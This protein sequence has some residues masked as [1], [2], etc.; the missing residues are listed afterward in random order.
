MKTKAAVNWGVGQDWSIEELELDDPKHGEVL[1]K[2]SA[3]GL[4]HSDEHILTGDMPVPAHP[5]IGGH[6]GAGVVEQVG[7]GV[8]S[9]KVGDHVVLSF[10]PACGRCKMCSTGHQNLCD[11]GAG[12]LEGL[13]IT[14]GTSRHH[15]KGEDARLMCVLGTFSPYTVVNEASAVKIDD[16]I[17][18]ELAALVGCG[19][20]TGWGSAVNSADVQPGDV[21]VVVGVGGIGS[22]AVQGA[23]IAGA[24]YIVAV[25]PVEFKRENAQSLG[26]THTAASIEEA[27]PLVQQITRGAM[28]DAV[29]YTAG[30]VEGALIA[31]IMALT[32]KGGTAV[33]TGIGHGSQMDVTMSLFDLTLSQKRLQGS[34]F[35]EANPRADIPRL[36]SLYQNGQLKLNELV[37]KTY[38]LEEIN[39]GY[40]DMRDGKNIR[41][42][43]VYN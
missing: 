29:I 22:N 28:A 9:L 32:T 26:A 18:L 15:V 33:V 10:I 30:V 6:E 7:P 2:L 1:I 19:V 20:T 4:C 38:S 27:F 41:G 12:I 36:L 8:E 43:I 21:V 5:Y 11:L 39:Q 16:D 23:R 34:L 40:Q 13:Q 35:G 37:T 14:D 3:S 25:D 42:V 17:P 24:K 31:G